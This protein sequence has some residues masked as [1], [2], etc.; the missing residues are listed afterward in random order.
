[1]NESRPRAEQAAVWVVG[2]LG[3]LGRELKEMLVSA[4]FP[5]VGTD[6]ECDMGD[7]SAL[8]TFAAGRR[9]GWIVNAAAYTAVDRAEDEPDEARRLNARGA[10]NC[11]MIATA[12][13][14][15]LIHL[16][17]DY[18]FD[19]TG[20][21]PYAEDDPVSP[22]GVYAQTKAE[23]ERLVLEAC[24][25]AIILRTAWLYGRHGGNFVHTMLRLMRER[26]SI[27]V[28]A[29][30][31]GTP[32]RVRSLCAVILALITRFSDA[33][34]IYHVTDG[35]ETTWHE[36]ASAIAEEGRRLGLIPGT[37]RIE[38]CATEAYPTRAR[39][40][41][42]SVLS[43]AKI[44]ALLGVAPTPWREALVEYLKGMQAT[45]A[46]SIAKQP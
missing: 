44:T 39:R 28:V 20:R 45:T 22:I 6:R 19:G 9:I 10:A 30:Q 37:C 12:C 36:F 46:D 31:F 8:R 13:G 21:R 1:M 29:D 34:G 3:M 32:T 42:Y 16:S 2:C 40:P 18:V 43:K 25:G 24:P 4:G 38:P 11:A 23:G 27:Q 5:C 7:A 26:D 33:S 35:G 14:A 15:R 17:T 41:A